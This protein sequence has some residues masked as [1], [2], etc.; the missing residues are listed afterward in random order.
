VPAEEDR[1]DSTVCTALRVTREVIAQR[2]YIGALRHTVLRLHVRIEIAVGALA[3]A[4]WQVDIQ[5]ERDVA[6]HHV[7]GA[8]PLNSPT[9]ARRALPR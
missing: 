3:H 6:Q 1:I 9:S 5:R 7:T 4:P 2:T 8:S